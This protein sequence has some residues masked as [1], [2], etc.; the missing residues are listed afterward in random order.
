MRAVVGFLALLCL[1]SAVV[2]VT[3]AFVGVRF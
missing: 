3:L 1:A 2:L